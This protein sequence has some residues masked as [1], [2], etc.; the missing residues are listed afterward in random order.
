M[1]FQDLR[2]TD[3]HAVAPAAEPDRMDSRTWAMLFSGVA[4]ILL[5]ALATLLPLPYAL[6]KPGPVRD[7]LGEAGGTPLIAIEGQETFPTSG[8]LDLLTVRVTGGPGSSTTVWDVLG[9]WVDSSVAVRPVDE[10][11]P[12][13]VTEADI[14][15]ENAAEMVTSQETAT[16]AAL[17]EL[18]IAVPTILT[19]AG[20][21][22]DAPADGPLL[23][24][25][26]VTAVEGERIT[27]LPQLREA[28]QQVEPGDEVSVGVTREGDEQT[29]DV[30]TLGDGK[31]RT[32]LGVYVDPT[33]TFPFDVKIAIEDIGGPS[34]GMMFALGIVDKLTPGEMTGGENIAG[35]GTIDSDGTVGPIGGIQ[36]KLVGASEAGADWFLAPTENCTEVVDHVPD[37]LQVVEVSNLDEA[38]AAVEAIGAG[39]QAA[40]DAMP[41]CG[42]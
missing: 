2:T 24:D 17:G 9:G 42:S 16:A 33:Y 21:A 13:D 5:F 11:F 30:T 39:D 10:V 3:P 4:A 34:A 18:D 35:T 31:G 40:V 15:A 27:D 7:V 38:R 6:M 22:E 36:Q 12:P 41:S 14:E 37:G 8:R 25:D 28:L 20:F 23:V 19:V 32:I 1:T 26:V 29:I